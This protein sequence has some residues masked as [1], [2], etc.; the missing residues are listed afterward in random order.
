[1]LHVVYDRVYL[2]QNI[3]TESLE[4]G[5]RCIKIEK[6]FRYDAYC[7]DFGPMNVHDNRLYSVA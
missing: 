3:K 4:V 5:F 2:G 1:M 6:H 7:D